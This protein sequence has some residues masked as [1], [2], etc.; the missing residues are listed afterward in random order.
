MFKFTIVLMGAASA[1]AT[2][3]EAWDARKEKGEQ[4]NAVCVEDAG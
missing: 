2:S 3:H 1:E 4:E